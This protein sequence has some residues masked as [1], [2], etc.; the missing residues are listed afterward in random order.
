MDS[1]AKPPI[2]TAPTE[3]KKNKTE[4]VILI[5]DERFTTGFIS[6]NIDI[7]PAI[8]PE[9]IE[10]NLKLTSTPLA[11][12]HSTYKN[13]IA[14][15]PEYYSNSRFLS[16]PVFCHS[17]YR[18]DKDRTSL[19]ID[20]DLTNFA[21]YVNVLFNQEFNP[22]VAWRVIVIFESG[23]FNVSDNTYDIKYRIHS[24]QDEVSKAQLIEYTKTDLRWL[25][26]RQGIGLS[27]RNGV[28]PTKFYTNGANYYVDH[29]TLA[30]VPG[31]LEYVDLTNWD[32]RTRAITAS[33]IKHTG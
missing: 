13:L 17:D 23:R 9:S 10:I 22:T 7:E 14:F 24:T 26:L 27:T 4:D 3:T 6:G 1:T 15:N 8:N 28:L 11:I 29:P 2:L 12:L 20:G 19:V 16:H 32:G 33:D 25:S 18:L 5:H 31:G 30:R 21:H